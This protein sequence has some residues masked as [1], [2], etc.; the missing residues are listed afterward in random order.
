MKEISIKINTKAHV[1]SIFEME[2]FTKETLRKMSLKEKGNITLRKKIIDS[3]EDGKM[4]YQMV[5]D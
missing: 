4:G 2:T 3:L 5:K 1:K